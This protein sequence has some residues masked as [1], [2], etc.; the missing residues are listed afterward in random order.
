MLPLVSACAPDITAR[1]G[2]ETLWLEVAQG[3]VKAQVFAKENVSDRPILILVLHSD[4]PNPRPDSQY[5]VAQA[6]TV[7]WTDAPERL[8]PKPQQDDL[9]LHLAALAITAKQAARHWHSDIPGPVILHSNQ[10]NVYKKYRV[11]HDTRAI[12]T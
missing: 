10:S 1:I 12:F 8:E 11:P 2:G 9:A 7:G 6:I 3:R 4:I 5:L